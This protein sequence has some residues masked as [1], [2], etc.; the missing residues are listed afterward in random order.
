MA[1]NS[2]PHDLCVRVLIGV[3]TRHVAR[4]ARVPIA[5]HIYNITKHFCAVFSLLRVSTAGT[6]CEK[7]Q[8]WGSEE[9][10]IICR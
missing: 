8:K 1:D 7:V 5:T 6:I 10:N 9:L 4:H 2:A 3:L